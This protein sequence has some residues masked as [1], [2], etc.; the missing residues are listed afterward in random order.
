MGKLTGTWRSQVVSFIK[1]KDKL[2]N[3]DKYSDEQVA[4]RPKLNK[5]FFDD[6]SDENESDVDSDSDRDSNGS[7]IIERRRPFPNE[8]QDLNYS[9]SVNQD[10]TIETSVNE[11]KSKAEIRRQ[12]LEDE[13]RRYA[14]YSKEDFAQM[15][16]DYGLN[17]ADESKFKPVGSFVWNYWRLKK[18]EFPIIYGAIKNVLTAP[19]SSSAVERLFSKVSSFVTRNSNAYKAKNLLPLIQIGELETFEAVSAEVFRQNGI[20]L[21]IAK[22][23]QNIPTVQDQE[24]DSE[25]DDNFDI[26]DEQF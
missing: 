4:K 10:S 17:D 14:Q 12:A 5:N 26:F 23:R 25:D 9:S 8:T 24:T 22:E 16:D 13:L 15:L 7:P 1:E 20:E 2:L 11:N 18:H 3:P 6:E 19:T 21:D